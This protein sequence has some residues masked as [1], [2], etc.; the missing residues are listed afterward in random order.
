MTDRMWSR[1]IVDRERTVYVRVS[2]SAEMD[3]EQ[4]VSK[5]CGRKEAE[6]AVAAATFDFITPLS[7]SAKPG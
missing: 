7:P 3:L 6:N 2:Q 4:D 5:C 1:R